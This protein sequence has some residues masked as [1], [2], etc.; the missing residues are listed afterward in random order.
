MKVEKKL[1]QHVGTCIDRLNAFKAN[2]IEDPI[3]YINN[4]VKKLN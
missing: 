4:D 2:G 3:E 1:A